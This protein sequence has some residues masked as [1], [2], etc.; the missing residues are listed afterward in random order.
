MRIPVPLVVLV[1][2]AALSPPLRGQAALS[3]VV[4]DT[5][6]KVFLEGIEVLLEGSPRRAATNKEGKFLLDSIP[7]GS[8][9]FLIRS[10][11]YE[12]IRFRVKL[13]KADTVRVDVT[14]VHENVRLDPIVVVAEPR[15]PRGIGLEA[16]D[17]RRRRG[18]GEFIDAEELQRSEHLRLG[19][20]LRRH[21]V[22]VRTVGPLRHDKAFNPRY[23]NCE[24]IV[25]YDGVR[26][27]DPDLRTF[28]P[29]AVRAVEVYRGSAE[30][31]MEY[32]G[33]GARCGIILIWAKRG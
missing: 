2:S 31:P 19:D 23:G 26:M 20:V 5:S 13:K 16:F 1:L 4:H 25:Y 30:V 3:G 9:Y 22:E 15:G 7:A 28:D 33:R 24:M 32:G 6:G 17:E 14:M 12:A 8:H 21:R 11:G 10:I 29:A 27:P 18:L